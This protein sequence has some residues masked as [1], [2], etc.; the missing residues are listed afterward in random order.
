MAATMASLLKGSESLRILDFGSGAGVFA[1]RMA[2]L[3]FTN[4]VAY[5]PFSHPVR[6]AG[7]FDL[8][9][10]IEVVEH[11]PR[12]V[13]TFFEM[14]SFTKDTGA[15]I[16]GQT[17]QPANI[18]ELKCNWWYTAPRNGHV[19]TYSIKTF[20]MIGKKLGLDVRAR[21]ESVGLFGFA[22]PS[23]LPNLAEVMDRLGPRYAVN[24]LEASGRGADPAKWHGVEKGDV[25]FRW[26]AGDRVAWDRKL[27]QG[28]N[29]IEVPFLMEIM[30]GYARQCRLAVERAELPTS[31]VDGRLVAELDVTDPSGAVSVELIMPAP[32]SPESLGRAPDRRNLGLAIP[33]ASPDIDMPL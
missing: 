28:R 32:V 24:V 9:T 23:L 29:R 26:T 6:P 16:V 31:I 27:T 1:R 15:L 7:L 12:P 25:Q 30:P 8:V 11:T 5:D 3:G 13:E 2:D 22:R 18:G 10:A 20:A 4:V 33:V 17:L 14:A 21:S 19:S